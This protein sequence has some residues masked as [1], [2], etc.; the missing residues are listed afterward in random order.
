MIRI[1]PLAN[2]SSRQC[3]LTAGPA[4]FLTSLAYSSDGSQRIIRDGWT[5]VTAGCPLAYYVTNRASPSFVILPIHPTPITRKI[6]TIQD[7]CSHL[8][9]GAPAPPAGAPLQ[10]C[11]LGKVTTVP[12]L[13]RA[14]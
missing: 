14:I 11:I 4:V 7:Q 10:W 1:F 3:E 5:S 6:W 12:V 2:S 8:D 13:S 9:G